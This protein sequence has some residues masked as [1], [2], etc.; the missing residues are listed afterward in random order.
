[1][2]KLEKLFLYALLGGL[3]LTVILFFM[4]TS[5]NDFYTNPEQYDA[6]FNYYLWKFRAIDQSTVA[7][8]TAW[9]FFFAHFGT[10]VYF[11]RKLQLDQKNKENG[12][13]KY[14]VYL[15]IANA[16][17]I[18]LHYVH[19]W[20][21][22]DA[23]AMDTPVWSSQGSV[24]IMLV[25]ILIIENQRRGLFFGKKL[26]FPK[27]STRTVMKYHGVYITL[28]TIF[29][30]WYH[31]MENTM[32]HIVGFVYMYLLFIQMSFART[33]LHQN[34]Y[35]NVTLEVMVLF[36][37]TSVALFSGNAPWS[38]FL[39]GFATIFFIT[40]IYGLKLKKK[41][42]HIAQALFVLL[43]LV[44][45]SG[46]FNDRQLY[47]LN[48]LVRIPFIEYALVFVFVYL[49]YIWIR[50][51]MKKWIRKSIAILTLIILSFT[52]ILV[53]YS[54]SSYYPEPEM[55]SL[56]VEVAGL[57]K[58]ETSSSIVYEY[59]NYETNIILVP[60]GKVMP[61]A[62]E[63]LAYSIAKEGYKVTIV[64]TPFQLAILSPYQA[65]KFYE[66]DKTNVIMGHSLGGV[67]ASMNASRLEYDSLIIMG[68]YPIADVGTTDILLLVGSEENLLNNPSYDDNT[69][70]LTNATEHIIPGGNHAYFGYYGNQK[71]DNE[72]LQSNK[73]I[74]DY[75]AQYIVLYLEDN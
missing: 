68:S 25:L 9:G 57:E 64:K 16:V 62:Y 12:Y 10:V 58:Y 71:G 27:E 44:T 50:I 5:I 1:M 61:Q 73:E 48:E 41:Y 13:S 53:I 39:F 74:Q 63:Y 15:L 55:E 45:Y 20:V 14:N 36:H 30:F 2:S 7:R 4:P 33:K 67:V 21:W 22:Y 38:M 47:E 69:D 18:V 70:G 52:T 23:L 37:G 60:G 3:V 29:T 6:G 32:F 51:P 19:T 75:V 66:E 35:F 31:P 17:F 26:P 46:L 28:A 72:A 49:I 42:I 8:V 11:L 24:I 54:S 43:A 56:I 59:E 34:K 65:N 40:Q